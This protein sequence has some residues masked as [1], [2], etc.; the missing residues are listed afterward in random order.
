MK[1]LFTFLFFISS[2]TLFAQTTISG[3]VV[4]QKGIAVPDANVYIE[5]SYDGALTDSSGNFS[6]ETSLTL[7]QTL[8]VSSLIYES[9]Q[10]IAD[11]S[12]TNLT[13]KLRDKINSLDQVIV[14][15]GTMQSGDRARVSVLKPLDIVTTAGSAGDIIAALQTLP[16][17]QNV[18]ESGRLFVRGGE[19]DETQTYIDGLR[20]AQPY[21]ASANNLPTRGRFSPFLFSGIAFSTGGYSAEFGEALSGVLLLNT[22]SDIDKEETNIAIMTVGL[23]LS[24][25]KKWEKSAV[26]FSVGYTDLAGYNAVLPQDVDWNKPYQSLSGEVVYR[27][28]FT[29]GTLKLYTAFDVTRFDL[30]HET[31][32]GKRRIGTKNRNLYSNVSYKGSLGNGWQLVSGISYGNDNKD[33]KVESNKVKSDENAAHL[34]LNFIKKFSNRVKINFGGDYFATEFDEKYFDTDANQFG[35]GFKSGI[36]AGFAETDIALTDNFAAKVGVRAAHNNL[37]DENYI[38]P[39]ISFAYRISKPSQFSIAYGEFAQAPKQDYLKFDYSDFKNERATH[40]ILN[41]QFSKDKR[42]L[43]AEAYFKNY[44]DLVKYDGSLE[45]S[46]SNF[47]NT[48]S[49]YA[50]GL[51]IFWR[52][53]KSV[54]NLEYWVSY[55]FIDSQRDFRNYTSKVTPSFVASHSLS[56]VGK[57]WINDLR[58]QVSL[59]QSYSSGR[60]FND[61]NNLDFMNG[62]TKDYSSLSFGW[63]YLLSTQKILYF[64]MSNVLG[65]NNVF[66]YDYDNVRNSQGQYSRMAIKPAASRFVFVGFFW[67]ISA[68]KKSNQLNTL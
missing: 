67:T 42:I 45:S 38:S 25:S 64:S 24:Q 16:G 31:S 15:A 62:K 52:D 39:R 3:K 63:A 35:L 46:A 50:K 9:V 10:F 48:G 5:G 17:T 49:G 30:N 11:G 41:Y 47:S 26:T 59:T 43:I 37:L 18:G 58:S 32:N 27:Y 44:R 51:D 8:V 21:N 65:T 61:P 56:L 23:G 36:A 55:S 13:I 28:K 68:D 19:S 34:K 60:P 40:Y 14:T 2:V 22:Q 66:G 4:D 53:N 33:T 20:V 29:N 54:E 6:F 7:P 57:Y 1:L 12:G